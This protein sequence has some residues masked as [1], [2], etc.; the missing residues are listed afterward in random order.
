[1]CFSK[2]N[3]FVAILARCS[4]TLAIEYCYCFFSSHTYR[5][6]VSG[7]R[8]PSLG[9]GARDDYPKSSESHDVPSGATPARLPLYQDQVD[10]ALEPHPR[11]PR[12]TVSPRLRVTARGHCRCGGSP[13]ENWA[14]TSSRWSL[15]GVRAI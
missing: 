11:R 13:S 1:M 6:S 8:R 12:L 14:T 2:F 10:F 5:Y 15:V 7:E 9:P 3:V 4:Y